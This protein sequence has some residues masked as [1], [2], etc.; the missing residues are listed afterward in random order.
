M[1][2]SGGFP[3]RRRTEMLE[4]L[5]HRGNSTIQELA[6][7]FRVST[8]T[9]RRDLEDLA[10]QGLV[11][12]THGGVTLTEP[13]SLN[14]IPPFARRLD[15]HAEGKSRIGRSAATFV[16]EGQTIF[17]NGGTTIMAMA[18]H[19]TG[20]RAVTVVTNNLRLPE[21]LSASGPREVYVLGGSF[22]LRS[23]VTIGPVVLPDASGSFRHLHAHIAFIGVGGV[24]DDGSVT[25]SSLPEAGI[26]RAMM[27]HADRTVLLADA[28]KFG[29]RQFAEICTLSENTTV[30][31]D[32]QPS[33]AFLA[34]TTELGAETVV[35]TGLAGGG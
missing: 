11:D 18:Q 22:R 20:V 13:E 24:S 21:Q 35:A 31:T 12:R 14:F 1:T 29:R 23:L 7:Q 6:I 5:R 30:I 8:D 2:R 9:V 16:Q 28:S 33:A 34:T 15:A 10:A 4:A 26:M 27:D 17:M 32:A 3:A 25:T 19:L